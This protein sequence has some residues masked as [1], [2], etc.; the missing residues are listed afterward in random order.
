MNEPLTKIN[1]KTPLKF[2]I[3]YKIIGAIFAV[4]ALLTILTLIT[5]IRFHAYSRAMLYASFVGINI[6]FAFGFWQ[7]K[8]WI[9]V[10]LGFTLVFLAVAG[11]IRVFQ[12]F[13]KFNSALTPFLI[14]GA[15]FLFSYLSR[16]HLEGE[17]KNVKVISTFITLLILS[18]ILTIF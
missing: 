12:D 3:P 16:L 2:F 5:P 11:I 1:P 15:L 8:K 6:I 9:I 7:M 13:Q 17:Y 14:V 18:Q 4:M 10:V